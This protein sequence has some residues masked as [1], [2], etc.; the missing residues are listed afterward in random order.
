MRWQMVDSL[1]LMKLRTNA[2]ARH[3]VSAR[4]GGYVAPILS[5]LWATAPYLHNG[6]VPTIWQ[7]MTPGERPV[8][9]DVGGHALD[10]DKL[11]IAGHADS[12]GAYRYPSEY[13]P[14]STPE[15]YDTRKPGM[16][17]RGHER[18]FAGL[19]EDEKRALIEYLKTL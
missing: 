8:E 5:G 6:S 17:N 14:W 19:T 11:G 3:M 18:Q 9:F 1:L 16:S 7:L 4:T 12:D 13:M 15:L 10:Y 2:Y